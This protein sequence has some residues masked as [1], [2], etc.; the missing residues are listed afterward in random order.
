MRDPRVRQAL[1][2][3]GVTT[4]YASLLI[5]ANR[6]HLIGP[7]PAFAGMA[8]T[9]ALAGGRRCGSAHRAQSSDW[10]ADLGG[11]Q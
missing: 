4:L 2:G 11:A 3:A 9:T 8:I 5:A 7:T 6:Y 1:A 10:S